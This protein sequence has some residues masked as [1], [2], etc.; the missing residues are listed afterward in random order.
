MGA[1]WWRRSLSPVPA[2]GPGTRRPASPRRMGILYDAT[3]CIG[4]KACMAACKEYNHL[5]PDHYHLR[6][7][8]GTIR[9]DLSAKTLQHRQTCTP[10][11]PAMAKD[12]AADGYSYRP[13]FLHALRRSGVDCPPVRCRRL[14]KDPRHRGRAVQQGRSASAAGT[15]RLPAPINV[16]KFEWETAFPQIH[17]VPALRPPDLPGRLCG[18]LRVLPH[19]RLYLRQCSGSRERSQTAAVFDHGADGRLPLYA[20]SILTTKPSGR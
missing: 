12:Q 8:R 14:R 17:E 2:V 18:L 19:W 1:W 20:G 13:A 11:A 3:L 4:C 10:T 7:H 15:A 16:P 5:P 9:M 6:Q